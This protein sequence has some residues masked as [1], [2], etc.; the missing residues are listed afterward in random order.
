MA[1]LKL[2]HRYTDLAA[3]LDILTH[4]RLVLLDPGHWDDK[5]DVYFMS[6][7]K[8]KRQLNTLLALCFTTK[9]ETYHHWSVFSHG[10][11]GV[12]I[13]FHR[14]ALVSAFEGLGLR[15][16]EVQYKEMRDSDALQ[17]EE[18]PFLKRYPYRDEKEF[19]VIFESKTAQAVKAVPFPIS[20]IER[21]VLSPWLPE[22]LVATIKNTLKS[23][24]GCQH[25]KVYRTTLLS[26][27]NW[28]RKVE[29]LV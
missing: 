3:L 22:P 5:N 23:I 15:W 16:G 14:D 10:S 2:L 19:R 17:L 8:Q 28:R 11:S 13:R 25:L 18:V 27:D 20:A 6:I 4:Q 9:Y 7:Y 26:N 29:D 1:S 21:V 24:D 12:C